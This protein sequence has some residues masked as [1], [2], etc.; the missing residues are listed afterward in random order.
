MAIQFD[1]RRGIFHAA[2]PQSEVTVT[3]DDGSLV[4]IPMGG[5]GVIVH[6]GQRYRIRYT[7][8]GV[9]AD[10]L[11]PEEEQRI[12][13]EEEFERTRAAVAKVMGW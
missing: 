7:A 8:A 2:A 4:T 12:T 6:K 9:L 10:K 13:R 3:N 5:E 1:Q 11:D